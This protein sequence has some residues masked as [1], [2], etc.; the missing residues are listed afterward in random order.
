V[1]AAAILLAAG[2]STRAG[3]P[4]PLLPRFGATLVERQVEALPR[5]GVSA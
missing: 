5:A 1:N 3:N 2:G 4:K